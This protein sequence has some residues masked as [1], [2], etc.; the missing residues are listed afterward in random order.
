M[1]RLVRFTIFV[2]VLFQIAMGVYTI[3]VS[4]AAHSYTLEIRQAEVDSIQV[5]PNHRQEYINSVYVAAKEA[6]DEVYNSNQ[7]T[8][9]FFFELNKF[10][11]LSLIVAWFIIPVIC[12]KKYA[13]T[14]KR[15]LET[16]RR[17]REAARHNEAS[18]RKNAEAKRRSDLARKI[19]NGLI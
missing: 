8:K 17:A 14:K 19:Q 12:I 4:T 6:R 13:N 9:W 7:Y 16:I 1:K 2:L 10:Q 18:V 11:K 15:K 3:A 5:H